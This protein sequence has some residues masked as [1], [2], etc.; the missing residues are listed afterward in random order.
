MTNP[1]SHRSPAVPVGDSVAPSFRADTATGRIR[2]LLIDDHSLFRESLVRLLEREAGLEVVAHCATV[3]EAWQALATVAVDVVLLDYY[4]GDEV[5]TDLLAR[6]DAG[7]N[8]ARV[9]MVTAGMRPSATLR[10]LDAGVSGVVLKHSDPRQLIEAIRA[11][12]A[13]Q[14]WWDTEFLRSILASS[15]ELARPPARANFLTE[16]QRRVLRSILDGLTNKEIATRLGV[17]EASAKAT[18]QELFSKAGVR[19]RSQLV[20][21]AVERYSA[22]WL[23]E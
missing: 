10:A 16:R 23:H 18:I 4:Q 21:I 9:M 19:T 1:I 7:A 12:A 17:S 15:A 2:I 5:G 6:L 20:R 3:A 13:G 14:T 11:V 8:R 22:D